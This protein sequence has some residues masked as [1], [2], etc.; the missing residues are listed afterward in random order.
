MGLDANFVEHDVVISGKAIS[1][2]GLY[3]GHT[4]TGDAAR[5]VRYRLPIGCHGKKKH[6]KS[7]REMNELRHSFHEIVRGP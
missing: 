1:F 7:L 6:P 2:L 3:V 5:D 4:L